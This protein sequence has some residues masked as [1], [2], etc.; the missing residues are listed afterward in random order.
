MQTFSLTTHFT[1]A[2]KKTKTSG[3]YQV[4]KEKE[5]RTIS[6][7]GL[8]YFERLTVEIFTLNNTLFK[9]ANTHET[10][11]G[12]IKVIDHPISTPAFIHSGEAKSSSIQKQWSQLTILIYRQFT[13]P[14]T[15]DSEGF[16]T[17]FDLSL[18]E[19]NLKSHLF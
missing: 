12:S 4:L 5:R 6:N 11:Q 14:R 7:E 9:H 1:F 17:P 3:I 15:R 13:N 10:T 18:L 19:L 2:K 8:K 16:K